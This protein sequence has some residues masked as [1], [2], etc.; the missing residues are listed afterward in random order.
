[1]N[2]ASLAKPGV[3][4]FLSRKAEHSGWLHELEV[5]VF[6]S[7]LGL[8]FLLVSVQSSGTPQSIERLNHNAPEEITALLPDVNEV[9][10]I[11][12]NNFSQMATW[13]YGEYGNKAVAT[14][15]GVLLTYGYDTI[16]E[17]V[18][19]AQFRD[20][21]VI[22]VLKSE[23]LRASMWTWVKPLYKTVFATLEPQEKNNYRG[24]AL[25]IKRYLDSYNIKAVRNH[26]RLSMYKGNDRSAFVEF[27]PDGTKSPYRKLGAFFDRHIVN[28]Q[29]IALSDA[30]RWVTIVADEVLS[31]P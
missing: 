21:L 8:G 20:K 24:M 30:Q 19:T 14:A 17:K 10:R 31:W 22:P 15:Y 26:L 13:G 16:S 18:S 12:L 1:M 25:Y 28:H 4:C 29:S 7:I 23:P 27:N 2:I 6:K 3:S 9:L 5:Y 11:A